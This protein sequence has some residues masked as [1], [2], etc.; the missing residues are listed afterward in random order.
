[1]E[2]SG[3]DPGFGGQQF[4]EASRALDA[5]V[6]AVGIGDFAFANDVVGDN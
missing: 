1:L 4:I 3:A 5:R 6:G 2:D